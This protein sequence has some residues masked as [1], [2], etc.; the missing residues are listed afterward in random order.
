MEG[1]FDVTLSVPSRGIHNPVNLHSFRPHPCFLPAECVVCKHIVFPLSAAASC[2][3]CSEFCHRQC[4]K[5]IRNICPGF[6]IDEKSRV[7]GTKD[8]RLISN[9]EGDVFSDAGGKSASQSWE[10]IA[11]HVGNRLRAKPVQLKRSE[12]E[13]IDG[14]IFNLLEDRSSFVG[15][16]ATNIRRIYLKRN[17]DSAIST[18]SEA[19]AALDQVSSA[20]FCVLPSNILDSDG[21]L[22]RIVNLC[23]RFLLAKNDNGMYE[24]IMIATTELTC[25][26]DASLFEITSTYDISASDETTVCNFGTTDAFFRVVAAVTAMD[27][28]SALSDAL[29]LCV[30]NEFPQISVG[31]HVPQDT[32]VA[33]ITPK[34]HVRDHHLAI[35]APGIDSSRSG[36]YIDSSRSG[37][38]ASQPEFV[39]HGAD[40]LIERLLLVICCLT[41]RYKIRWHSLCLFV[42]MMC[43]DSS[44][45]LGA[46]GYS[47]VTLQQ[48]LNTLHPTTQ[49]RIPTDGIILTELPPEDYGNT[50]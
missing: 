15:S 2:A 37:K 42:E 10:S 43:P 40:V 12:L 44:W 7:D 8:D 25:R 33:D 28:L 24:K 17:F 1:V 48:V 46:E 18:V 35:S 13:E 21:S 19:R 3:R 6:V 47:I 27:K 22:Q 32:K 50:E 5:N 23:D 4:V 38:E 16:V 11:K 30:S 45:L 20:L 39:A 49:P 14:E 31:I 9:D 41:R 34:K 26:D 36:R 29:R